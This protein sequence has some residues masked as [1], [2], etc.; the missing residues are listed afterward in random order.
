MRKVGKLEIIAG[1]MFA[2]KTTETLRRLVAFSKTGLK[3]LYMNNKLDT[4]RTDHTF[5]T[6]RQTI[7]VGSD[8]LPTKLITNLPSCDELVDYD[9]IGIDEGHWYPDL[10]PVIHDFVKAGMHVIIC[11]LISTEHLKR[12]GELDTLLPMADDITYLKAYC[13]VCRD[14][15]GTTVEAPF[16]WRYNPGP[17]FVGGAE[18][19]KAVCRRHHPDN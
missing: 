18:Q 1:P 16:S 17:S 13:A 10:L 7:V 11:G 3:V 4:R 19:Y 14:S 2:G 12:L 5:S 15:H 9:V 8:S 6:H